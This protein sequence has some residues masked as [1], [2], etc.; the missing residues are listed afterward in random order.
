MVTVVSADGTDIPV[1]EEGSGPAILMVHPGLDD[2]SRSK[3]LAAILAQRFR[4]LRLHRRQYRLDLKSKGVPCSVGQEAEDVL[5]VARAVDGPVLLYGHSSGAV[6]SLE[7]LAAAPPSS[8]A[9]AVI[10]EPPA[11]IEPPPVGE[12][13]EVL[14][15]ARAA[16][17][18]GH[19]AKAMRI[20]TRRGVGLPWWQATL[21]GTVAGTVPHLR[22]YVPCQIDDLEAI[23]QLGV[24][25]DTYARITVPTVLLGGDRSPDNLAER[26]DVLKRVLPHSERVVMPKRDHSA[27][28]RAPADVARVVETLADKVLPR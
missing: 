27:D 14:T 6:V 25:L 3:K 5:A 4:V 12:G 17:A 9:G 20:F 19:P 24:R 22:K 18:A 8:F 2:G 23:Q 10:F 13:G 11:M 16:I 21:M 15:R 1:R 28:L 7:A 26:L